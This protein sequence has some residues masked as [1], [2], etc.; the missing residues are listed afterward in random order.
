MKSGIA[1]WTDGDTA[2]ISV[3]FTW[4]LPA[5]YSLCVWYGNEGFNVL[6]GGVAAELN[7]GYL[8]PVADIGQKINALPHHNPDA[9]FTSRG[10]I[11][12]CR[13]CA[14]PEL[15]G[16]LTEIPNFTPKPIIYDN[17]ILAC[18]TAHF[19][20]VIDKV[21]HL[22][23]VDFNQG[24]DARLLQPHHIDGFKE[25]DLSV[26]RLAWDDVLDEPAVMGAINKLVC[27]GFPRSKMRCYV[28]VNF[29]ES[30]RDA[31]YRCN[32]LK[33]MGVL[34]NV[35]RYQPLKGHFSLSKDSYVSPHWDESKL[36]DF[37]RYWSKQAWFGGVPFEQYDQKIRNRRIT[38]RKGQMALIE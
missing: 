26:L 10:C 17:N 16:K 28:L 6:A 20:R 12:K 4:E 33:K 22:K 15:E 31:L 24:L 38:A 36:V 32:T 9:T 3:V 1:H 5:A 37:V 14:V 7:P 13:F 21:K 18:S 27:A 35:Q 2:F 19:H 29:S 23:A 25:L 30:P 34:P 11:R 8:Q